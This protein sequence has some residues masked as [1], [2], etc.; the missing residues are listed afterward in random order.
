MPAKFVK[1]LVDGEEKT[2]LTRIGNR[3]LRYRGAKKYQDC[4]DRELLT[5]A[6]EDYLHER[7]NEQVKRVKDRQLNPKPRR[8]F[9]ATRREPEPAT[10]E[11]IEYVRQLL[12]KLQQEG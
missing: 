10:P 7:A 11:Q 8:R 3:Y 1:V 4:T 12:E 2:V 6:S 5:K 9:T